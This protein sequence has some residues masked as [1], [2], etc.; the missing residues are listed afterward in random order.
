M[1]EVWKPRNFVFRWEVGTP[2]HF[3]YTSGT[4]DSKE[5]KRINLPVGTV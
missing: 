2:P 4:K 5:E 1:S 3:A